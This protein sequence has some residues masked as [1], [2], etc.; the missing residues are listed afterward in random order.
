[1]T[2]PAQT[3]IELISTELKVPPDSLTL[4]TTFQDLE[5]DSLRI[6]EFGLSLEEQFKIVIPDQSFRRF[7]NLGDVIAFVEAQVAARGGPAAAGA[8]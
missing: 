4:E 3:I 8:V 2:Q 7:R 6:I 1:M 5:F